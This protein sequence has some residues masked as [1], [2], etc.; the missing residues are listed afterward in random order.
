MEYVVGDTD[1]DSIVIYTRYRYFNGV[2]HEG[3]FAVTMKPTVGVKE[4]KEYDVVLDSFADQI[5]IENNEDGS[6][7]FR[8]SAFSGQIYFKQVLNGEF[9]AN[10]TYNIT[11]E[12]IELT[13]IPYTLRLATQTD[14]Y[15][16]DNAIYNDSNTVTLQYTV[17][18]N[19]IN[20]I[21]LY[22]KI[23]NTVGGNDTTYEK[24]WSIMFTA[25]VLPE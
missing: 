10:T 23:R 1:I 4:F 15:G 11:V 18:E 3:P 5:Y 20:Q 14:T 16:N 2:P 24:A 19:D 13:G 12:I 7:F 25:T 21:V 22:S 17:G 9:K 6:Y 8:A